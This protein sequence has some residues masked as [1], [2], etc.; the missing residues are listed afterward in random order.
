MPNYKLNLSFL[1]KNFTH[2]MPYILLLLLHM[3]IL[4]RILNI[5][6]MS[7]SPHSAVDPLLPFVRLALRC[8]S[9]P[10]GL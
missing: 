9:I 6:G 4:Q 8:P 1:D 2:D 5:V 3:T 10:D 7:P